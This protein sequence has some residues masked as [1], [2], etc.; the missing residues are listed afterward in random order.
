MIGKRIGILGAGPAAAA[1]AALL[2]QAGQRVEVV[3]MPRC[4]DAVEGVSWRV[5]DGL[6]KAGFGNIGEFLGKRWMRTS[7][8]SGKQVEGNGECI[9]HRRDFDLYL[10]KQLERMGVPMRSAAIEEARF[11]G[12]IW[13]IAC[14]QPFGL[15]GRE[16]AAFDFLVEARGRGAAKSGVNDAEGPVSVA[17]TRRFAGGLPADRERTYNEPFRRGWA[18]ATHDRLGNGYVQIVVD[19]DTLAA[20]GGDPA[21][22]WPELFAEL[23]FLRRRLGAGVRFA[24]PLGV[25][26]IRPV[27]RGGRVSAN[28]IRVGDACYSGD[29]LSGHGI[30]EAVAG[31]S[32]VLPVVNTLFDRPGSSGLAIEYYNRR[33][34]LIFQSRME[35]AAEFYRTERR[36]P[37]EPFWQRRAG[38]LCRFVDD[39]A[40]TALSPGK[41]FVLEPVVE[42]GYIVQRR[43]AVFPGNRRGVRFIDGVDLARLSDE[44]SRS[45]DDPALDTLS[46]RLGARREAVANAWRWLAAQSFTGDTVAG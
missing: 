45:D 34:R 26:G 4:D 6:E 41:G 29:P 32:A 18:W 40:A 43:V 13:R 17:L 22:L 15:N 21:A 1:T 31:A 36:W 16:L 20:G 8:W 3:G 46:A 27:L 37:D 11:D 39:T 9:V 24:A 42:N 35:V 5:I 25:R 10:L 38:A 23:D 19:P 14:R 33:S 12:E 7:T 2:H 28:H 30:F 44:I